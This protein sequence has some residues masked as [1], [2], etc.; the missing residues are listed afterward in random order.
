[1][2]TSPGIILVVSLLLILGSFFFVAAEYALVSSRR[3]R[4]ES[5]AKKGNRRAKSLLSAM[6]DVS[7]LVAASQIGI[8]M[9]GIGLGSVTEPYV[10]HQI[11]SL[12]VGI[13]RAVSVALSYLIIT[14]VIVVIGELMPKYLALRAPEAVAQITTAPLALLGRIAAPLVWL[15]RSSAGLLLRPFGIRIDEHH[16]DFQKD[17]LLMMIR[18]GESG[19]FLEKMHAEFVSRT[20]KLDKLTAKDIMVHRL[21][22]QWLDAN[23]PKD[24]LFKKLGQIPY[25]RI[26]VCRGDID[27]LVGI[28]YLHDF[29]KNFDRH[30]FDMNRIMRPAVAVP[31]NLTLDRIVSRMRED[32]TQMLIVMD[33]Y[34]GTSGLITLE[35][36]V[37]EIFGELEDKLESERPPVEIHAAGRVTARADV[38]FDEL[39]ARL[40]V[41]TMEDPSTDTLAEMIIKELG[42]VPRIG[43]RIETPIGTLRVDNMARRRITRVA[44]KMRE[45]MRSVERGS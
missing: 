35:D 17:E 29:V 28:A 20:L 31:E 30:D 15:A 6:T 8:T 5:L 13:P 33:E 16:E 7:R 3:S 9:V 25:T 4:L 24:E 14:Y 11:E 18:A 44:L 10:S 45:G 34:G 43:D 41:D 40:G 1:M 23:T 22:I 12:L 19:G 36:V 42:R 21:D 27:D 38:R 32:R 39:V 26:P 37:E 2:G